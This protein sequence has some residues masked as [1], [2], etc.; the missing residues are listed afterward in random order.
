MALLSY[1]SFI[2]LVYPLKCQICNTALHHNNTDSICLDCRHDIK[3]NLPPFCIK[4]GR[5]LQNNT[6]SCKHKHQNLSNI[7]RAWIACSYEGIVRTLIH[8]LKYN[9]KL[10]LINFV[11]S[12]CCNFAEKFIDLNEIDYIIYVPL[13]RQKKMQR[14]F[15]QSEL[16][17]KKIAKHFGI[18]VLDQTLLKIRA[19][20][21]QVE[22]DGHER[23]SNLTGAFKVKKN[24]I[25][26]D[27]KVLIIDDVLT[28]GS[29][30]NECAYC[31][32]QAGAH[33]VYAF[34]LAGGN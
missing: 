9:N 19:T 31:L 20:K 33:S 25:V 8:R 1:N 7:N 3:I 24:D 12:I 30:L 6:D 16:I 13:D 10:V 26:K 32:K 5:P 27:K 29:T 2:N 28:T 23:L 18:K 4:C 15:N 11:A 22:I 34:T 21:S 14:D 17:A